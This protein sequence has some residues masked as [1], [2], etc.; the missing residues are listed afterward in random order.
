VCAPTSR[1]SDYSR[2]LQGLHGRGDAAA[3]RLRG[4]TGVEREPRPEE[5]VQAVRIRPA[6]S[7]IHRRGSRG[8]TERVRPFRTR[9][10][11]IAPAPE[12]SPD[13][14]GESRAWEVSAEGIE[15]STYGLRGSIFPSRH[16]MT[17]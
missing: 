5:R 1:S 7:T 9:G 12:E 14:G 8:A 13:S 15:P 4:L 2:I 17:H 6:R 16:S 10:S 11:D 3:S